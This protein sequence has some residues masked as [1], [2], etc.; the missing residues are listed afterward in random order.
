MKSV[1]ELQLTGTYRADRHAK[2]EIALQGDKVTYWPCPSTVKSKDAWEEIVIPLVN[3][4][5]IWQQDRQT[6]LDAFLI[7]DRI[8][9]NKLRIK[10][11]ETKMQKNPHNEALLK[12]WDIY[13]TKELRWIRAYD[14]KMKEFF[15][16]PKQRM[17]AAIELNNVT[18]INQSAFDEWAD[19]IKVEAIN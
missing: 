1:E 2:R 3:L 15:V 14:E 18:P 5:L 17:K 8:K 16:T 11:I 9:K 4:G 13:T 10:S 6:I 19:A 12:V 7:L